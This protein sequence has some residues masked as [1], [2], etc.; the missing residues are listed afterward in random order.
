[1]RKDVLNV[2]KINELQIQKV[3]NYIC[4]I[5]VFTNVILNIAEFKLHL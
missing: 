3:V 1:M 4:N 2:L 5:I